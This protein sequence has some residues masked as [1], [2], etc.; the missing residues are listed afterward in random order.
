MRTIRCPACRTVND[1]EAEKCKSCDESL[2]MAKI[3][4]AMQGIRDTTARFE[5]KQAV[6]YNRGFSS[7]N[8]FGTMLL[9]YRPRGDGTWEAVR[10]VVAAGIPLVPLGGYVI[11]PL[12]RDHGYRRH[13]AT[14]NVLDRF[15]LTVQRAGWTYLLVVVGL[16]P[17]VLGW[18]NADWLEDTVG[19]ANAF[20]VMLGAIAW[21]IY[22]VHVRTRNDAK[23]FKPLPV[24]PIG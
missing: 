9:D 22:F 23:A 24:R 5:H 16:L 20:F 2:A 21:A 7:V 18:M 4:E 19:D 12:H 8:G 6:A 17:L 11:Q 14:F 13:T 3:E 10:W 1:Y 15:P